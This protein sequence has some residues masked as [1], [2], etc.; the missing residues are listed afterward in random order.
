MKQASL[1]NTLYKTTRFMTTKNN[2]REAHGI[3]FF[4]NNN[5]NKMEEK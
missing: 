2:K 1:G 5:T 3:L 4:N